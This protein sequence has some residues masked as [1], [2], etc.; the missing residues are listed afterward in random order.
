MFNILAHIR[1]ICRLLKQ[2]TKLTAVTHGDC[3]PPNILLQTGTQE[4]AVIDFQL[5]RVASLTTDILFLLNTCVD[6]TVLATHWDL[7]LNEYYQNFI[8]VLAKLGTKLN[9]TFDMFKSEINMFG[10]FAFGMCNEALMGCL[11][12]EADVGDTDALEVGNKK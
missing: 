3:W 2:R 1:N 10:L 11:I 7:I 5:A 4:L 8:E 6:S 9:M 12:D